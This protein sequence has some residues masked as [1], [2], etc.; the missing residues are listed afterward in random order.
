M[1]HKAE[2]N[3]NHRHEFD[4]ILVLLT[5]WEKAFKRMGEVVPASAPG[6]VGEAQQVVAG[7]FQ[8][9][10]DDERI[11]PLSDLRRQV[12]FVCICATCSL[13]RL[14]LLPI[15]ALKARLLLPL[16]QLYVLLPSSQECCDLVAD[17]KALNSDQPS[18][19]NFLCNHI[20]SGIFSCF[21]Q[22]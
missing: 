8:L 5:L 17:S 2:H 19:L 14:S 15:G 21:T 11:V 13:K 7:C 12:S 9:H 6:R 1:C 16:L 18:G 10:P 4:Q 20:P 3:S 22:C